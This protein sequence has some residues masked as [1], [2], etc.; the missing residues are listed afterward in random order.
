MFFRDHK[1]LLY[2]APSC[3]DGDHF[4]YKVNHL[5]WTKVEDVEKRVLQAIRKKK[6][7]LVFHWRG[8]AL[9]QEVLVSLT[10][11]I[12]SAAASKG[13]SVRLAVNR[14]QAVIQVT[15]TKASQ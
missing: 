12:Q 9:T 1:P 3:P 2:P 13:F 15:F 11:T 4:Y 5:S 7:E 6:T 14:P 8:G 10:E